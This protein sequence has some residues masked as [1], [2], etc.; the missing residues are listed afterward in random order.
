M[1]M[2]QKAYLLSYFWQT[3]KY[4]YSSVTDCII[5]YTANITLIIGITKMS[6]TASVV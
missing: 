1:L 6:K 2:F 5:V 4:G 3:W